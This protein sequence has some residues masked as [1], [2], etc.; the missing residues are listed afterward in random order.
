MASEPACL[1]LGQ[2]DALARGATIDHAAAVHLRQCAPCR[3]RLA[4]ASDDARL[5]REVAAAARS[6]PA[7]RQPK[8]LVPGYDLLDEIHRGGQGVVYRAYHRE[9]KRTVAIKLPLG[10]ELRAPAQQRRFEREIELVAQLRHPNIVTLFDAGKTST[11]VP[12][13]AMEYV[14][15]VP[16]DDFVRQ[17][18]LGGRSQ[19]RDRDEIRAIVRLIGV[20]AGAVAYAHQRGVI[21]RDLKPAN[22]L[23]DDAGAPHI[24]DFG[25]G[26]AQGAGQ[27]AAHTLTLDGEFAGTLDYA[28][29]EQFSGVADAV[30]LRC[31]IYS[32]GVMLY[33]LLTGSSPRSREGNLLERIQ[34][35]TS[36]VPAA[37]AQRNPA[38]D[39]GVGA[40]VMRCLR[41]MPEER[42][43]S[44]AA[45]QADLKNYLHDRPLEARADSSWYRITSVVRRNRWALTGAGAAFL[46]LAVVAAAMTLLYR[47][48]E[49]ERQSTAAALAGARLE[50]ARLMTATGRIPSAED[51]L[52]AALLQSDAPL[53]VEDTDPVF[54][55][56]IELYAKHPCRRTWQH[57]GDTWIRS[58]AFDSPTSLECVF[59]GGEFRRYRPDQDDS[60]FVWDAQL[61]P[62]AFFARS[63]QSP[64]TYFATDAV[65][66]WIL[67]PALGRRSSPIPISVSGYRW[68]IG[69]P[70][71]LLCSAVDDTIAVAGL[72]DTGVADLPKTIC[73]HAAPILKVAVFGDSGVVSFD[74][75]GWLVC[76]DWADDPPLVR[77]KRDD[78]D[79]GG[80]LLVDE[81][82]DLVIYQQEPDGRVAFVR[83]STGVL[84][85]VSDRERVSAIPRAIVETD[86]QHALLI[87]ANET[88]IYRYR[89]ADG[90]L[91]RTLLGHRQR[92]YFLAI[93][94]DER[95]VASGTNL[96]ELKLWDTDAHDAGYRHQVLK[97]TVQSL[98]FDPAGARLLVGYD[99][100]GFE[101]EGGAVVVDTRENAPLRRLRSEGTSAVCATWSSDGRRVLTAGRDGILRVWDPATGT[102]ERQTAV[103]GRPVIQGLSAIAGTFC[104][105]VGCFDGTAYRYDLN[106]GELAALPGH[107]DR[108]ASIAAS[109]DGRWI[110]CCGEE[111]RI[112]VCDAAT[113]KRVFESEPAADILRCVA[114]SADGRML[115]AAG[116][117]SVVHLYRTADWQLESEIMVREQPIFSIAFRP[118]SRILATGDTGGAIMLWDLSTG[119]NLLKLARHDGPVFSLAYSP[120]GR[121]L[122]SGSQDRRLILH[123]LGYYHTHIAGN[124]AAALRRDPAMARTPRSKQLGEWARSVLTRD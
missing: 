53:G 83:L 40:I 123:D 106:T 3:E 62:G 76:A 110:A 24:L 7:P 118:D 31:D 78:V 34:R 112:T 99:G 27:T 86:R 47:R 111:Q 36:S 17:R 60:E 22:I 33:E 63:E 85:S 52:W 29:P 19:P 108:V 23:I 64:D 25:L 72:V 121:V 95:L 38:L 51:G 14:E 103:P 9:T 101:R 5:I 89:I 69:S 80:G 75:A 70:Q 61:A 18:L 122:A 35:I 84:L 96:R 107:A 11:G 15:G 26:R 67:Q 102:I 124:L 46:A 48:A 20:I 28:A 1:T 16:L 6:V 81:D 120:D 39:A 65:N 59:R 87:H 45:L 21:H 109:P 30:D 49:T 12:G 90:S 37:A 71:G 82:A 44:A 2:I 113:R 117:E 100:T 77:W 79:P 43:A 50:Q 73:V 93:S 104:A 54:W 4:T 94:P 56:L 57:S 98:A 10:G 74:T 32:I 114:F 66:A 68:S 115:A 55:A 116:N 91:V 119:R 97:G 58:L 88:A 13:Y 42:Y 105:A 41:N 8:E 92:A